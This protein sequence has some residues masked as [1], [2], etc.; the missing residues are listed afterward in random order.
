[1]TL[2]IKAVRTIT[3]SDFRAHIFFKRLNFL[4]LPDIIHLN[5]ALLMHQFNNDDLP[6]NFNHFF[7]SVSTRYNYR[8]RLVSL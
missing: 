8:T 1:M 4:K 2:K 7:A 5:T 3:F 6:N